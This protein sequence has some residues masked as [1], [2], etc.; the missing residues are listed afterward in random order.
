MKKINIVNLLL[1]YEYIT[2]NL[3]INIVIRTI[4]TRIIVSKRQN[5]KIYEIYL[6]DQHL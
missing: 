2:I 4:T 3:L 5:N 1:I 6:P